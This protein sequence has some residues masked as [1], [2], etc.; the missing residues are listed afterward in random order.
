MFRLKDNSS[1]NREACIHKRR[2]NSNRNRINTIRNSNKHRNSKD[3]NLHK[4]STVSRH[5]DNRHKTILSN[6]NT[7]IM[8]SQIWVN[9]QAI[10]CSQT[11]D[12][13]QL[14]MVRQTW[15]NRQ[16]IL[17]SQTSANRPPITVSH[18][19]RT[20]S[21]K[22]QP[23]KMFQTSTIPFKPSTKL[24][25]RTTAAITSAFGVHSSNKAIRVVS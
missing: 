2:L 4:D 16:L 1:H 3:I 20:I 18:N 23:T 9:R 13:H 5:L 21:L 11:S 17:C 19:L 25:P 22:T 15:A 24:K 14:I 8:V 6:N 12:S 7:S 10:Q